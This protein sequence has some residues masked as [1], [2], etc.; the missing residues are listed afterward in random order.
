[1]P[2][3]SE[4]GQAAVTVSDKLTSIGQQSLGAVS[5]VVG[6]LSSSTAT[7]F[8][9]FS[10]QASKL[11]KQGNV[12]S[13]ALTGA[14][15]QVTNALQQ[16]SI[17]KGVKKGAP[18]PTEIQ[19]EE[20]RKTI[21]GNVFKFPQDPGDH[22]VQLT[23]ET[24]KKDSPL[25]KEIKTDSAIIQLPLTPTMTETYQANYKTEALNVLGGMADSVVKEFEN[26]GGFQ[27][28]GEQMGAT[29][30]AAVSKV[31]GKQGQAAITS[32]AASAG[33]AAVPGIGAAVSKALGASINPNMAVLFD[34]IGFR[35]H[36]FAFKLN[37]RNETESYIIK[38]IIQTMR[39]RMLPPTI[40]QFFFGFPDKV[41]IEIFPTQPYPILECVL[42]SMSV[43]YAPNGPA[44]YRG[45]S[46]NPV[47]VDIQLQFKEIELF[48]RDRVQSVVVNPNDPSNQER[49]R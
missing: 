44:F 20:S 39:R 16:S 35:S 3:A 1:M 26:A 4:I 19:P 11:L 15:M 12:S 13:A 47:S 46:G 42:E 43:N 28:S 41:K 48:T 32:L 37:P 34:N 9:A 33:M 2:S 5:G 14:A 17:Y 38:Q 31:T 25:M 23:F 29:L 7:A 49:D 18:V 27:Q 24:F 45:S 10:D 8:N 36:Q 6:T 22:F 40:N 21:G 30:G